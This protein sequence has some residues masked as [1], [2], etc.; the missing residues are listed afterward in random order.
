MIKIKISSLCIHLSREGQ[1]LHGPVCS[2]LQGLKGVSHEVLVPS[3]WP[4][5]GD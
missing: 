1:Q 2:Q 5:R 3:G 4:E